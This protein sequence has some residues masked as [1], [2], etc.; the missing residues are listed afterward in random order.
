MKNV[1]A[2]VI[3]R[4]L[5][6]DLPDQAAIARD[7]ISNNEIF[8]AGE[9]LAE[10]VYVLEKVYRV[11]RKEISHVLVLFIRSDTVIMNNKPVMEAA[12]DVYS[13][14]TIDYVDALLCGYSLV[15]KSEIITFDKKL[16]SLTS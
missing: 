5:L 16:K 3:L 2:N 12:L 15:Q 7:I 11:T 13:R 6:G 4:Y 9:V 10:V 8:L 14:E 1:D